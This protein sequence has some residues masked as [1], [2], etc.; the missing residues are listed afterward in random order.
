MDRHFGIAGRETSVSRRIQYL[1]MLVLYFACLFC[2]V[3]FGWPLVAILYWK[4]LTTYMPVDGIQVSF[5]RMKCFITLLCALLI[6]ENVL[7]IQN[8]STLVPTHCSLP[9]AAGTFETVN[10]S[11]VNVDQAIANSAIQAASLGGAVSI[12]IFRNNCLFASSQALYPN[13]ETDDV[14]TNLF[15]ATKSVISILT[16]MAYDRGLLDLD[17]AIDKYLPPSVLNSWGDAAHRAI[18]IRQLLTETAGLESGLASEALT[19]ILDVSIPQQA[20]ALPFVNTPGTQFVYSQRTPDLLAY[21]VSRAVGQDLQAFAQDNL[22]TPIGIPVDH[23]VWFRD[24]SL[25]S[26]GYAWLYLVADDF[27]RLGLLMQNGGVYNDVRILSQSYANQVSVPSPTNGCYGLLFW[28]NQISPTSPNNDT[29]ISPTGFFFDRSWFPSAP[30]DLFAM[31]GSP[32]QKNYIIP[33]LNITISWMGVVPNSDG[34]IGPSEA[35]YYQFFE[36]LMTGILDPNFTIP[37]PGTFSVE[38]FNLGAILGA[39]DISVLLTAIADSPSC[40]ILFCNGD[41]PLGGLL[42]DVGELLGLLWQDIGNT[43]NLN[44]LLLILTGL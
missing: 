10:A 32:Q 16:G 4:Y 25:N 36:T 2:F 24:R 34:G 29:C 11:Q 15:S 31:A 12:K 18:T 7:A 9:D 23:Y 43:L 22:F 30:R 39:F 1:F 40:N 33:S 6:S 19:V 5:F 3:L 38:P 14:R 17:D 27:A 13:I 42:N 35:V 26:Y 20:L 41:I 28:T 21:V 44:N 37:G 8:L